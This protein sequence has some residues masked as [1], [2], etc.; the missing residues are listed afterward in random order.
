MLVGSVG[1]IQ[2]QQ[3]QQQKNGKATLTGRV[4]SKGG[5]VHNAIVTLMLPGGGDFNRFPKTRTDAD[6]QFRFDNLASGTYKINADAGGFVHSFTGIGQQF[7]V[8]DGENLNNIEIE[9]KRGGA[10]SGRVVDEYGQAVTETNI[11]LLKIGERDKVQSA[12]GKGGGITDDRGIYRMYGIPAGRYLVSV[13]FSSRS[14]DLNRVQNQTYIAES[15]HPDTTERSKANVIELAEDSEVEGIDITIGSVRSARDIYGRIIDAATGKGISGIRLAMGV[16][17]EDGGMIGG[18]GGEQTDYNGA[19]HLASLKQGKYWITPSDDLS[20]GY[21]G[22]SVECVLGDED[23]QGVEIKMYRGGTISGKAIF[24]GIDDPA[25]TNNLNSLHINS[26]RIQSSNPQNLRKSAPMFSDGA[27][28]RP[29][30]NGDF[31]LKGVETG[32]LYL[33]LSYR[34]GAEGVIIRRIEHQGRIVD[35]L[36]GFDVRPGDKISNVRVILGYVDMS[37]R[38]EIKVVGGGALPKG[39]NLYAVANGMDGDKISRHTSVNSQRSFTLDHLDTGEYEVEI[40][41][42]PNNNEPMTDQVKALMAA[43]KISKQKIFVTQKNQPLV[44]TID[45]NQK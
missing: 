16:V 40:R 10:I 11:N 4:V 42:Y 17:R 28:V 24:E 22:E 34:Q 1:F 20:K 21:F 41:H 37:L 18:G 33:S 23:L 26:H 32:K 25:I 31:I 12:H 2:S 44:L 9:I 19:F 35:K 30:A 15:F 43:L 27:S 45:L 5:P 36:Q 29:D 6:G 14:S 38:G 39:I 13:G 8:V 3:P 7:D